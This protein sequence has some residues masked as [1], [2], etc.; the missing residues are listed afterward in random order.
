M[1]RRQGRDYRRRSILEK[2][3]NIHSTWDKVQ[4]ALKVIPPACFIIIHYASPD[5]DERIRRWGANFRLLHD[6][7]NLYRCITHIAVHANAEHLWKNVMAHCTAVLLWP[8]DRDIFTFYGVY[9]GGALAGLVATNIE[10]KRERKSTASDYSYGFDFIERTVSLIY[11]KWQHNI[12]FCGASAAIYSLMCYNAVSRSFVDG[13]LSLV[14]SE[15]FSAIISSEYSTIDRSSPFEAPQIHVGHWAH[16]GGI[17]FG[18][19]VGIID[20][21]TNS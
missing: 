11:K 12:D 7:E 3:L 19:L 5:L 21:L 6:S 17:A 13:A 2:L 20:A 1:S 4:L 9:F 16:F 15:A 18:A 14:F 8:R 10:Q